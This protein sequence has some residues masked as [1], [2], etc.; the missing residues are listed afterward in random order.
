MIAIS[1]SGI[2]RI[3][4][5]MADRRNWMMS[6]GAFIILPIERKGRASRVMGIERRSPMNESMG[7]RSSKRMRR[8]KASFT[9]KVERIEP[10]YE[11]N[12]KLI[13]S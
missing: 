5:R 11:F 12:I 4:S 7:S 6:K 8:A 10:R 3:G 1:S 9:S 2:E 13:L